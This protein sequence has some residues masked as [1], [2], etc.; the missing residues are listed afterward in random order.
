MN[1]G[2]SVDR[3]RELA[4]LSA[5]RARSAGKVS[6]FGLTCTANL[7]NP[8]LFYS[9]MRDTA[10]SAGYSAVLGEAR[11]GLPVV[12]AVN[13]IVDFIL[14]D[15]E[16]KTKGWSEEAQ[17]ILAGSWKSRILTYHPNDLTAR[18]ADALL[19]QLGVQLG[20]GPVAILGAGHLG[21]R[22]AQRLVERG[23]V[24]K[25]WR[26]NS[27]ALASMC[28]AIN[29]LKSAHAAGRV[30][31]AATASAAAAGARAVLG[32]AAGM[33]VISAEV[34]QGLPDD[35]VLVDIGN[36]TIAP[37]AIASATSRGLKMLC[38]NFRSAY[39]G[40]VTMLLRTRDLVE[41]H[42]GRRRVGE[43]TL[44]SGGVLG[45]RGDVIV[46]NYARPTQIF[47]IADG[48]GDV[49]IPM[50]APEWQSTLG[51][52]RDEIRRMKEKGTP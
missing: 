48:R 19:A 16:G 38:L 41:R 9:G 17:K 42:V 3:A 2:E 43:A 33:P 46:D 50:E 24:V 37:D 22:I 13:G 47:G 51:A 27:A 20:K 23:H 36:G 11:W 1:S 18:A 28:D 8:P 39:E 31:A 26:R 30:E 32:C 52:A 6:I 15:V 34:I 7:R 49:V 44:I 25:L 35:A 21:G 5:D 10:E 12:Q 40:E 45:N 29:I 14:L 4:R